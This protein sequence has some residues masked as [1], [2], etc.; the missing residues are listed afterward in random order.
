M[1]C[2]EKGLLNL[3]ED[4]STILPE[5]KDKDILTGFENDPDGKEKPI[6]VKNTKTI[7]LRCV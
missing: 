1:Q 4:V 6:L 3:D 2:V 5:L 7:T